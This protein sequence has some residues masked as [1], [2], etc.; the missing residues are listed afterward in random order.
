MSVWLRRIK[1]LPP[2]AALRARLGHT[3]VA[4]RVSSG[5]F[6]LTVGLLFWRLP[7]AATTILL[8]RILGPA[9][10]GE[11]GMVNSTVQMLADYGGL[12]VGPTASRY[13]AQNRVTDPRKAARVLKLTTTISLAACLLVA[14]LLGLGAQYVSEHVLKRPSLALALAV[15]GVL[16]L[17]LVTT[18]IKEYAVTGFERFSAVARVNAWRGM[19]TPFICL[20]LAYFGLATGAITG[21]T[22]VAGITLALMSLQLRTIVRETGFPTDV[23]WRE[24]RAEMPVMWTF[25]LPGALTSALM[26]FAMWYSRLRLTGH[27]GGYA[28]LGL[29]EAANQWRMLI[30]FMPD[31]LARTVGPIL[32]ASF[33]IGADGDFRRTVRLQTLALCSTAAPVCILAIGL[34]QVVAL[35]FGAGFA[36]AEPVIA[37]LVIAV[38]FYALNQAV[39]QTYNAVGRRWVNFAMYLLWA[40]TLLG[41]SWVLVPRMGATGLAWSMLAAEVLL[42]LV[43]SAFVELSLF[44][45]AIRPSVGI[46]A[47]AV[48]MIGL[49][50]LAWHALPGPWP[51]LTAVV[52]AAVTVTPVARK[53]LG[54][55][56]RPPS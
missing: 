51:V 4:A 33:G 30:L 16:L 43:Q 52:L 14:G 13:V 10:F 2:V 5:S 9:G 27:P 15:G 41:V 49:E 8:G 56:A 6:W 7:S 48:V 3:G 40:C 45:G 47:F 38:F 39:R 12:G 46:L 22:V 24:S 31:V 23:T 32:A 11:F 29:F 54:R 17:F 28:E 21:L 42:L 1:G 55:G 34:S 37:V 44:P 18:K 36:A 50:Y 25:A 26:A 19:V 35:L 53:A 20:P